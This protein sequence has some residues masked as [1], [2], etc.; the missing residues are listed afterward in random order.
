MIILKKEREILFGI[1][2]SIQKKIHFLE[3]SNQFDNL[4]NKDN[5]LKYKY[6]LKH[7]QYLQ[8]FLNSQNNLKSYK[9]LCNEKD[10]LDLIRI[11]NKIVFLEARL[12]KLNSSNQHLKIIKKGL[13]E[14]IAEFMN[15]FPLNMEDVE[16]K[17]KK[18]NLRELAENLLGDLKKN[19][20]K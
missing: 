1:F 9:F 18:G 11:F 10:Q 4:Q 2:K 6:E 17:N 7:Y 12:H 5:F 14:V 16:Q 20:K 15:F 19:K 8:I 3:K 13:G